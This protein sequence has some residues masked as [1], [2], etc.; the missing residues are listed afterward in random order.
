MLNLDGVILKQVSDVPPVTAVPEPETYALLGFG[1][2]ALRLAARRSRPR[3]EAAVRVLEAGGRASH[4]PRPRVVRAARQRAE[5]GDRPRRVAARDGRPL[6]RARAL[7]AD[8]PQASGVRTWWLTSATT[9]LAACCQHLHRR[10]RRRDRL[11]HRLAGA[12][13]RA[14]DDRAGAP[15]LRLA[16]V[17][18]LGDTAYYLAHRWSHA[19]P[20]LWRFHS[21]RHRRRASTARHTRAHV[22][23]LVFVRAFPCCRSSPWARA[24]QP[25]RA[26]GS[27]ALYLT[28][29]TVV[30]SPSTPTSRGGSA[31]SSTCSCRPRSP[32]HHTA[33]ARIRQT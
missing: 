10:G 28:A 11:G 17:V 5:E 30:P 33:K 21:V 20:W 8:P 18:V 29:T 32:F 26:R 7:A 27:F 2:A 25:E 31:G 9:S 19:A 13:R 3:D 12:G 1:P 24:R 15:W 6:R 16:V 14:R 4:G 23:D 22:F